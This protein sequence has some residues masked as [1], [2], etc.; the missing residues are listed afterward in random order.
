MPAQV[1]KL[2][3]ELG[4]SRRRAAATD[5]DASSAKGHAQELEGK[6]AEAER[7]LAAM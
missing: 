7:K 3:S 1:R 4:E 2:E 5:R 6:L